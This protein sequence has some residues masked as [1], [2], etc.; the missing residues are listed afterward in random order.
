MPV[1][2]GKVVVVQEGRFRLI[3]DDGRAHLFLL[4]HDA[5]LEAQDLLDL[6]RRQ[7][8]VC[9]DYAGAPG[10]VARLA[11]DIRLDATSSP[12]ADADRNKDDH[13]KEMS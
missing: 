11:R 1:A 13:N 2:V 7:A 3:S 4:T 6:A 9:V 10:L 8:R 12:G 5:P